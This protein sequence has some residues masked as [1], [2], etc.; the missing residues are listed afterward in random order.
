MSQALRKLGGIVN[1]TGTTLVF[2]NQLRQKIGVVFGSPE[3]TTGGQALRFDAAGIDD[4]RDTEHRG[5]IERMLCA[6]HIAGV[7]RRSM[8]RRLSRKVQHEIRTA[9]LGQLGM[10]GRTGWIFG[11][12]EIAGEDQRASR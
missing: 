6:V 5:K 12:R 7:E 9:K 3:T 2:I 10:L 1:R 8:Q 11:L 4:V